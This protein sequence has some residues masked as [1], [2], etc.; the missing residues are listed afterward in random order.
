MGSLIGNV[1]SEL[2]IMSVFQNH[3]LDYA[4]MKDPRLGNCRP[5][6]SPNRM[7][8]LKQN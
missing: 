8:C 2:T 6:E 7:N 4:Y 5:K 3:L 1:E